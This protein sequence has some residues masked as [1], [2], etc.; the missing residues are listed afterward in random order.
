M[1]LY[2]LLE[3]HSR[4]SVSPEAFNKIVK[5]RRKDGPTGRR[6]SKGPVSTSSW[7]LNVSMPF[8]SGM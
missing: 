1:A 8:V 6:H 2:H 4:Q 7:I 5:L 3:I